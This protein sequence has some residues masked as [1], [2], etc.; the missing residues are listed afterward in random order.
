MEAGRTPLRA[1]AHA[2]DRRTG[3]IWSEAAARS[4]RPARGEISPNAGCAARRSSQ[5]IAFAPVKR[6]GGMLE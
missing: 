1:G 4:A 2:Q 3:L 6:V 5:V